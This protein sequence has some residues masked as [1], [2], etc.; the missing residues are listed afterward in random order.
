[1]F[2]IAPRSSLR[3]A[4]LIINNAK[5][6]SR[7]NLSADARQTVTKEERAARRT[8]RKERANA[9]LSSIG[10]GGASVEASAAAGK[11]IEASS[12]TGVGF[13]ATRWG[14]YAA[15]LIPTAFIGWGVYDEDS[16]PAKLSR[17]IGLTDRFDEFSKPARTKLLPDWNQVS[18]VSHSCDV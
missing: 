9:Y 12:G 7:C 6:S 5:K 15:V 11:G 13:D 4:G 14:W 18:C 16:P 2:S 8:A 3:L 1:M 10:S 17:F